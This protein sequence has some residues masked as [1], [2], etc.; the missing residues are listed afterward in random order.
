MAEPKKKEE[1]KEPKAKAEAKAKPEK[2][3]AVPAGRQEA[4]PKPQPSS[5]KVPEGK[6]KPE[7]KAEAKAEAPV[8]GFSGLLGIKLGMTQ[9]FDKDGKVVPVTA[10]LAGPC[11]VI[12]KKTSASD[13]YNAVQVGFGS[14]RNVNKPKAG[15]VGKAGISQAPRHLR[16]FRVDK[17]DEYK[18]G[19][20]FNVSIFK[21]GELVNVTGTSIG[22]GTA[23]TVK[24]WHFNRGP[25]THGSKSHR[26]PGSIGAGTT[27][28]RVL[29]GTKMAGR[30]GGSRVT[31]KNLTV[32]QV[33]PE[34]NLL[35]VSGAV[36]GADNGLIKIKKAA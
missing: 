33:N 14:G 9:V 31:V 8:V 32:V 3:A 34:K 15:H 18:L 7:A 10:V 20:E 4:K 13:G 2:K 24:R 11:Y 25:M 29:K 6:P 5:A 36:P 22:K 12:Q 28:G 19:Q 26:L 16:E 17:V 30:L 27:P 23:G 21:P 1:K 35:L